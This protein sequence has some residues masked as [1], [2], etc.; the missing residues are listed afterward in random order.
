MEALG[1]EDGR[2]HVPGGSLPECTKEVK[3]LRDTGGALKALPIEDKCQVQI[4]RGSPV[5]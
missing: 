2:Y 3:D 4:Q 5:I 1:P